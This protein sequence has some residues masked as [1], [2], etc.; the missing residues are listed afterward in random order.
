MQLCHGDNLGKG[1][2]QDCP[3]GKIRHSPNLPEDLEELILS[4]IS[5]DRG[6]V[7][8]YRK[9]IGHHLG[10]F[11]D[12]INAVTLL[13]FLSNCMIIKAH[14]ILLQGNIEPQATWKIIPYFFSSS[15]LK[16]R[17]LKVPFL[18]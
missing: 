2:S 15:G 13:Q 6:G 9:K 11:P 8:K 17:V 12:V 14:T 5:G 1:F 10:M 18:T 4:D 7:K 16:S 3:H